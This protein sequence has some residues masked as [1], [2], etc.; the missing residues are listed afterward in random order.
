MVNLEDIGDVVTIIN[1]DRKIDAIKRARELFNL[2][3]I[4]A[5]C[6]VETLQIINGSALCPHCH[7][8]IDPNEMRIPA[9]ISIRRGRG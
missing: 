8:I 7:V 9:T 2:P 1:A 5:K 3:L 4:T 6:F